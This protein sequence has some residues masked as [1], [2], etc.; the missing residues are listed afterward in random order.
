[1]SQ[2][3]LAKAS[4]QETERVLTDAALQGSVDRLTGLK[5]NVIIGRMIPARLDRSNEGRE[6][7]G[8]PDPETAPVEQAAQGWEDALA[9]I[10]S[11]DV[12][13]SLAAFNV[14]S[15]APTVSIGF[16]GDD[17]GSDGDGEPDYSNL[18]SALFGGTETEQ[19]AVISFDDDGD[20]E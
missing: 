5:E 12:A 1:M 10:A 17:E 14:E 2:S 8:L 9:A 18:A 16:S 7:L 3:F 13:A 20:D 11:D 6:L 15:E 4:F 19:E